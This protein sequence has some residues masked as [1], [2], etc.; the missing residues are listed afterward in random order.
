[1]ATAR[2]A[3]QVLQRLL[4]ERH[5]HLIATLGCVLNHQVVQRPQPCWDLISTLLGG[6]GAL[7]TRQA[8]ARVLLLFV[9][10]EVIQRILGGIPLFLLRSVPILVILPQLPQE[11]Q[12]LLFLLQLS[13]GLLAALQ[14]L[15]GAR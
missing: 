15:L 13:H 14:S 10:E 7:A 8:V 4:A 9:G 6:C 1:M 2:C 5:G 11:L 12:V 3:L